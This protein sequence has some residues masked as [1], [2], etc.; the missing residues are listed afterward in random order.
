VK[1]TQPN[2]A[3]HVEAPDHLPEA[4]ATV[5]RE[6]VASNDLAGRVDRAALETFSTLVAR[7][8]E[9][10]QR[11]EDEG[12]VVT[13]PR[14]RV[15]PHPA[16]AVER[17]TA[18]QIRAWGDRFAPLV[19]PARKR[20]YM[21]DATAL[22][23]A[24]AKHLQG[25]RFAGPVAAV[26]TLAWMIDEAQRDSMEAMQKAMTTTVPNY[27]KACAELQITPASL[28]AA[29]AA[30]VAGAASEPTKPEG[31]NVSDLQARAAARRAGER[32]G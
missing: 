16:L 11:V 5:W 24:E 22:T 1:P 9:A 30:P 26:K 21:A 2:P 7:L 13:D 10:R 3:E 27:L 8:R 28:P 23:L 32:T 19:K 29:A 15:I 17:A 25:P 4:V 20:G 31:S 14:G 6:I 18:E 12:M